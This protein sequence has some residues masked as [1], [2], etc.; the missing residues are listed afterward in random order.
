MKCIRQTTDW[1]LN[2]LSMKLTISRFRKMEFSVHIFP[3]GKA[4]R[5]LISLIAQVNPQIPNS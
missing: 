5:S 2:A 4:Q 1:T 3:E